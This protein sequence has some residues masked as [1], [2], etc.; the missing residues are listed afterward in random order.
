MRYIEGDITP[1]ELPF[2]QECFET[3]TTGTGSDNNGD[4]TGSV[5]ALSEEEK[6]QFL[7]TL[8]NVAL[9]SDAFFPFRYICYAS[10]CIAGDVLYVYALQK[11]EYYILHK[12]VHTFNF[13]NFL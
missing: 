2:W 6:N 11:F 1:Y 12:C 9:S 3:T 7:G 10:S 8:Q 4:G 13:N 5:E